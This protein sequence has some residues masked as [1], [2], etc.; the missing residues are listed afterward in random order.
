MAREK[1]PVVYIIDQ[2]RGRGEADQTIGTSGRVVI[3]GVE[4]AAAI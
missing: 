4:R 3:D 1:P 2:D